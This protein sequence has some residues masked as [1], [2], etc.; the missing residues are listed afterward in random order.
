[1][2]LAGIEP[3]LL[4]ELDFESSASTSSA[5]GAFAP[6]ARGLASR[7]GRTI[8]GVVPGST[9]AVLIWGWLDRAVAA[10]YH[11]LVEREVCKPGL[12]AGTCFPRSC[13]QEIAP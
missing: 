2:P 11:P 6:S 5:T 10:G 4:A 12:E 8:A 7:S 3:A 9:R 1:V 13:C